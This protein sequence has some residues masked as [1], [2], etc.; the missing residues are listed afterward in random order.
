MTMRGGGG[1]LWRGGDGRIRFL[2]E[3]NAK[4]ETNTTK[5]TTD[6]CELK[7]FW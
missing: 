6:N 1:G 2:Q 5:T 3:L 7:L 4:I